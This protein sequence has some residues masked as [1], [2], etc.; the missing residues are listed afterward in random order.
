[1]MSKF[2]PIFNNVGEM[3]KYLERHIKQNLKKKKED[4]TEYLC[5][6]KID[7]I[8]SLKLCHRDTLNLNFIDNLCCCCYC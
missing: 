2:K 3:N 7:S 1:M 8:Y 5:F 6:H 4:K